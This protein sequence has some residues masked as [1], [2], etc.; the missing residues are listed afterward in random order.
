MNDGTES[1]VMIADEARSKHLYAPGASGQGKTTLF[2]HMIRHDMERGRGCAVFDP[3]GPL[4]TGVLPH[5]PKSRVQDVVFFD[6]ADERP[7]SLNPFMAET[8]PERESVMESFV[9]VFRR[10][11]GIGQEAP[12]LLHILRHAVRTLLES[13]NKTFLDIRTLLV[14][15]EFRNQVLSTVRNPILLEFWREEFPAYPKNALDPILNKL[16]Q[17]RLNAVIRNTL[18]QSEPSLDFTDILKTG[19]LFLAD[20]SEGKIGQENSMLLG[21]ILISL[22]Q[23]AIMRRGSLQTGSR[24]LFALYADEFQSFCSTESAA[25]QKILSQ[26]RNYNVSLNLAHQHLSQI[27]KEMRSAIL[28]N[29]HTLVAFRLGVEDA[30]LL[31]AAFADAIPDKAAPKFIQRLQN[32]SRG[33]ALVRFETASN[34]FL[35]RTYPP[36][37]I[38]SPNFAREV[39]EYSRTR[40]GRPIA[41]TFYSS[42]PVAD[43]PSEAKPEDANYPPGT[44]PEAPQSPEAESN[45][46]VDLWH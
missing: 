41:H 26:A 44:Q 4:V 13:R 29:V 39:I 18:G 27:P 25:F 33:E 10:V 37:P 15:P 1:P 7:I 36:A 16:G 45:D 5:V 17:F 30:K 11:F 46:E 19:K 43:T 21:S 28:G 22:L 40:Y 2:A 23:L 6:P 20:L 32:L 35:I 42:H 38:P 31:Q 14:N 12:R 34:N 3:L 9:L 8:E 24:P